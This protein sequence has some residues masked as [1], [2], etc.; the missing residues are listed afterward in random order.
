MVRHFATSRSKSRTEPVTVAS[1][2]CILHVHIIFYLLDARWIKNTVKTK[3]T[4]KSIKNNFDVKIWRHNIVFPQ[5]QNYHWRQPRYFLMYINFPGYVV[6]TE[7][8]RFISTFSLGHFL[9]KLMTY[10]FKNF[11]KTYTGAFSGY[12]P[13]HEKFPEKYGSITIEP[14][15]SSYF[16]QIINV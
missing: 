1:Q 14:L 2:K 9:T 13:Q 12:F 8:Q 15:W 7:Y 16:K 4:K 10:F 5:I 11:Y 3:A 6:A